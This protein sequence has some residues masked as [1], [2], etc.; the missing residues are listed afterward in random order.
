MIPPTGRLLLAWIFYSAVS[1]PASGQDQLLRLAEKN[2]HDLELEETAPHTWTIHTTGSDPYL[3]TQPLQQGL[4][5]GETVLTFEYFATSYLSQL[6]VF[7][8]PPISE[9]NSKS[10]ELGVREGWTS[11]SLDLSRELSGW[12]KPGHMLRLDFGNKPGYRIQIRNLR[13]RKPNAEEQARIANYEEKKKESAIRKNALKQYFNKNYPARLTRISVEGDSIIVEGRLPGDDREGWYLAEVPM[14]ENIAWGAS[15]DVLFEIPAVSAGAGAAGTGF[16]TAVPRYGSLPGYQADRLLSKWV[17]VQKEA[18]QPRIR[19]AARYPDSI[20]PLYQLRPKQPASKKGLGG[21]HAGKFTADLDSLGITSV[22]VNMWI[23]KMLRSQP[24][25][26]TIPFE[27]RGKTYYAD[28]NWVERHDRTLQ[29]TAKRDILV[30][31]IVLIDKAVN[32]PDTAIGRIMQHPDCDPSGIYSMANLTSPE[33]VEYYAAAMDFLARRYS[34]PDKRFGRVHHWIVHNEVDAGWVWT[35]MG[36]ADTLLFMDT[37][38]KSMRLVQNIARQYN[39]HAKAFISLTHYWNWTVDK[40]FYHSRDLLEILLKYSALE[41]DFDWGIAHHPYPESLFEPKSWEDEKVD[42]TFDTPLI[43]FKNVEV[44]DSWVKQPFT[45]YLGEYKRTVFLSEQGPN[46]RDYS[47]QHLAEQAASMAYVW[48]KMDVLDGIDAFQFHNWID[49]RG[50]GG[51]RIG[52]RRFPDDSE[53]P[54]G[55]KPVWYVYR[56][57]GTPAEQQ[58]I[59][60]A[61]DLIGI[62]DWE[63]VR[64]RGSIPGADVPGSSSP[65]GSPSQP[66]SSSQ[67]GNGLPATDG[68]GRKLPEADETGPPRENRYVGLFYWTWHTRLSENSDAPYDVSKILSRH[69]EA[70][71]DY[72]HPAW[73]S[74]KQAGSYFWSEPLFGYYLNTDRWVLYKHAEL[75]AD[76]GVDVIVFDCTNGDL[77]WPE[78]Y[79]VLCDVFA[80]ARKNGIKTPQI[81]FMLAFGPTAGSLHAMKDIYRNLYQ[82]GRYRD[83]WFYWKGKPL[84]MAYPE[85]LTPVPDDPGETRL[86]QEIRDFFTFRPGQPVYDQG[87]QRPDHWGWLEI[88]PQHGFAPTAAGGFEQVTVGVSQNWSAERGLTAM[89]APGAFGRSYTHS[90]GHAAA[91]DAVNYGLN[92]QEQWERALAM[93]PELIFITGWNEWIAGRYEEWQLQHNAFPDQYD[94]EHSRDIEPMA[95]GHGDNY[96]YQMVSNIRRFKGM[97]SLPKA[98]PAV[99]ISIDGIFD[100]W[101]DLNLCYEAHRGNTLH[102]DSPGWKGLHYANTTGRNDIVRVKVAHDRDFVYFYA[103][104]AEPLTPADQPGWMRLFIDVDRDKATGWEGYDIVVNRK[105]PGKK[106]RVDRHRNKKGWKWKKAGKIDYAFTG[107]KLELRIPRHLLGAEGSIDLEFKWSDH[108]QNPDVMDFLLHGD[109]APAGRFNYPYRVPAE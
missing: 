29:E 38:H 2:A 92:F 39:P 36:E 9:N 98:D 16:R 5:Q 75:L 44:L 30:S 57:L 11:Y 86:R 80:E 55:K 108:M 99:T 59:E 66:G 41:G 96:Y 46:S 54:A 48:K 65:S 42:F 20:E 101:D 107:R 51:L 6:Q 72:N 94:Q 17:I 33:G 74:P 13:F 3:F 81:A 71:G 69:P 50:E 95:G 1:F 73:P 109:A 97:P 7:W 89:N 56:D 76:A 47:P 102:R 88:Y 62:D 78:S 103:E 27:Y 37:Y 90:G 87:P 82:P 19:S 67:P 40:H 22:T 15:F 106:A 23:S 43:T 49:N 28:R 63:E 93:D 53:D 32:T 14:Y 84:I 64:Y 68:L 4:A 8:G 45:K 25:A 70:I 77:T 85:T 60:F 100:D 34:R 79:E 24:S 61:K 52:L 105:R 91:P 35:N 58:A 26:E 21:F 12:G 83:L 104:T 18:G 10:G 31:A